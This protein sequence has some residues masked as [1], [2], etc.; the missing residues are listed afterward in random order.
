MKPINDDAV[1]RSYVVRC[2]SCYV[3][4]YMAFSHEVYTV[5]PSYGGVN[6]T[7]E[8]HVFSV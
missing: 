2:P 7:E 6:A 1:R 4:A 3:D 8:V 5:R